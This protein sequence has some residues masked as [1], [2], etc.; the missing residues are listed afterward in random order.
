MIREF[1]AQQEDAQFEMREAEKKALQPIFK[2][3][4]EVIKEMAQKEGY[5]LIIEKNM[6]GIYWTSPE[7]E[8]TQQVIELYD[9]Y[10]ASKNEK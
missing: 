4:E 5:H 2:E 3:L 9:R 6:P 1:R 8:I 10:R 7:V